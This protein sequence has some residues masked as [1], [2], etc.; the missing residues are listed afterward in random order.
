MFSLSVNALYVQSRRRA[1]CIYISDQQTYS[2]HT[3][4]GQVEHTANRGSVAASFPVSFPPRSPTRVSRTYFQMASF[5]GNPISVS[6]NMPLHTR[7]PAGISVI[8][9]LREKLRIRYITGPP[10][11]CPSLQSMPLIAY[12]LSSLPAMV[13]SIVPSTTALTREPGPAFRILSHARWRRA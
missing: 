7:I 13:G 6:R 12:R 9:V 2:I 10:Q 3:H 8:V 5:G 1:H 11:N 4:M